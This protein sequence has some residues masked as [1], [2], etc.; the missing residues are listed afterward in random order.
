VSVN[1]KIDQGESMG[2]QALGIT[3]GALVGAVAFA[4]P[5]VW[6]QANPQPKAATSPAATASPSASLTN[7]QTAGFGNGKLFTFTYTENFD[8]V[9]EPGDDLNFNGIPVEM[10]PSEIHIP[11]CEVGNSSVKD[12]TGVA[13]KKT[14]KLYVLLPF[15]F[16]ESGH[17][18]RGCAI[19]FYRCGAE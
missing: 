4:G 16:G 3:L 15:F 14:D 2:K 7:N 19:L 5:G 1:R 9:D 12:P 13:V 6:A 8:C 17:Q 18:S 11:I 10:D